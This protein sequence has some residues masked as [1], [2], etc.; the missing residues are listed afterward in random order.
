[1][2][3]LGQLSEQH[4]F[5]IAVLSQIVSLVSMI[6]L[7]RSTPGKKNDDTSSNKPS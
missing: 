1:M 7:Y 2:N 4:T 6:F 3:P 5:Y